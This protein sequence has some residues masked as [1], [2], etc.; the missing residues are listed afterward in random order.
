[1][2]EQRIEKC[3]IPEGSLLAT[4]VQGQREMDRLRDGAQLRS[5][6]YSVLKQLPEGE[7]TLVATSGAGAGLAAACAA[8]RDQPTTWTKIDLL[9]AAGEVS[10]PVLVVDPIDAGEGWRAAI[11][12]LYPA[13]RFVPPITADAELGLAA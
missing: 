10:K 8:L 7:L 1:M 9:F 5:A 13:A 11:L 2:V 3:N 6:A 4:Y 12:R